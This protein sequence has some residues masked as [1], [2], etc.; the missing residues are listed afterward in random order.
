M[1]DAGYINEIRAFI[2]P[3]VFGGKNAKTPVTG[4]GIDSIDLAKKFTLEELENI[5][6]DIYAKYLRNEG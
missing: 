3:K 2:A 1:I 6:G 5:D 4:K